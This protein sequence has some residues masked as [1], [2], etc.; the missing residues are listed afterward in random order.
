MLVD[1]VYLT[2]VFCDVDSC[3]YSDVINLLACNLMSARRGCITAAAS[4]HVSSYVGSHDQP[5]LLICNVAA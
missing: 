3:V 2:V 1:A 5:Q 4:R